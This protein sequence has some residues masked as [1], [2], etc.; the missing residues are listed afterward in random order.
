MRKEEYQKLVA[1]YTP[2]ENKWK[3]AVVAF[4]IGVVKS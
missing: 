4:L 2:K 3:N 1:E